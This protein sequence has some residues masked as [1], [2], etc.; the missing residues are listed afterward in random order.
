MQIERDLHQSKTYLPFFTFQK[1]LFSEAWTAISI[2]FGSSKS[3]KINNVI[4]FHKP[5]KLHSSNF[6]E[7]L[8]QCL[9]QLH[10]KKGWPIKHLNSFLHW[11]E[12]I[13]NRGGKGDL[14]SL[15]GKQHPNLFV[16]VHFIVSPKYW[17]GC[18]IQNFVIV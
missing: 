18:L 15:F 10:H 9:L 8:W 4:A 2:S 17:V 1:K 12:R 5:L 16:L 11:I 3:F 7:N 13:H 14:Q 6:N